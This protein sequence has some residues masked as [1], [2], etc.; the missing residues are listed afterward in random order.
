MA[1][2]QALV[3]AVPVLLATEYTS[4]AILTFMVYDWLITLDEEICWFWDFRKGRRLTA[5]TLLYG[6]SRYPPMVLELFTVLTVLPM[7]EK[8]PSAVVSSNLAAD[9]G[10]Q[11]TFVLTCRFLFA[12]RRADHTATTTTSSGVSSL[13][14]NV[15]TDSHRS[16]SA[17]PAF[18]ASMGSQLSTPG[19]H[20]GDGRDEEEDAAA[21]ITDQRRG[22]SGGPET[23]Y[24]GDEYERGAGSDG[25]HG[26]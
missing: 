23:L 19:L 2:Q 5:A 18:I 11:L 20:F 15:A 16:R 21:D 12:L 14:F 17:L 4:F 9:I 8:I 22:S 26:A 24:R 25:T 6:L 7:S 13:D 10:P 3:D 1:S